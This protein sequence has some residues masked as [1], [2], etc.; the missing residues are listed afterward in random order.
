MLASS[1][2]DEI[3]FQHIQS[4]SVLLE[5]EWG[6]TQTREFDTLTRIYDTKRYRFDEPIAES[7]WLDRDKWGSVLRELYKRVKG[8]MDMEF[9]WHWSIILNSRLP[10]HYSTSTVRKNKFSCYRDQDNSLLVKKSR[11]YNQINHL[12]RKIYLN[13]STPTPKKKKIHSIGFGRKQRS[14]T[15]KNSTQK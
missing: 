5:Q 11:L 14:S 1:L 13:P 7:S 3:Q 9:T 15:M 10:C 2:I 4:L 8:A 12:L 6:N